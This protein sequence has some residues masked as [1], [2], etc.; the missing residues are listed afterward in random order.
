MTTTIYQAVKAGGNRGRIETQQ[1]DKTSEPKSRIG[2]ICARITTVFS[3]LPS[4]KAYPPKPN[5]ITPASK[6]LK[7][8]VM[9][10][11]I[12][13]NGKYTKDI[14]VTGTESSVNRE[15]KLDDTF[16]GRCKEHLKCTEDL[17][18][19][20]RGFDVD[21]IGY[22]QALVSTFTNFRTNVIEPLIVE[23]GE[24]IDR[25]EGLDGPLIG[26]AQ[27][28][29]SELEE[30]IKFFSGSN[31]SGEPALERFKQSIGRAK[32]LLRNYEAIDATVY[33]EEAL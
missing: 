26:Q 2:K 33:I 23:V 7:E 24:L 16:V 4:F 19:P 20:N 30:D 28:N 9:S 31:D 17:V 14:A 27:S 29:I 25:A 6:G 15:D 3:K 32:D 21:G 12:H 1:I 13:F 5:S 18:Y 8:Q 10:A 22:P 11:N